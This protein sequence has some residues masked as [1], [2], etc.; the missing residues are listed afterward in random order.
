MKEKK[1]QPR[2]PPP[3]RSAG[4]WTTKFRGLCGILIINDCMDYTFT[5]ENLPCSAQGACNAMVAKADPAAKM[6][7]SRRRCVPCKTF[8]SPGQEALC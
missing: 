5:P 7:T 3:V 4:A 1:G 6:P 8:V 2:Q